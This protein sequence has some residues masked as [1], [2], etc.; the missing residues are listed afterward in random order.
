MLRELDDAER[1]HEPQSPRAP[2]S[3]TATLSGSGR[4][5][6][7]SRLVS[8]HASP[9]L[10]R[11]PAGSPRRSWSGAPEAKRSKPPETGPSS[12][13]RLEPL[14]LAVAAHPTSPP[15]QGSV[16]NLAPAPRSSWQQAGGFAV[17]MSAPATPRIPSVSSIG[18]AGF[19]RVRPSALTREQLRAARTLPQ[20][21][22][23]YV[24][25]VCGSLLALVDQHAAGDRP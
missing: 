11:M 16:L 5:S 8:L 7:A 19:L 4:P 24:P 2:R 21:D 22:N 18:D 13:A 15:G 17:C 25:V 9:Q 23:K 14:L 6:L 10:V 3:G 12:A 20:V 1:A